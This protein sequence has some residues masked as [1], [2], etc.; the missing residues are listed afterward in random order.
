MQ[1]VIDFLKEN[2]SGVLA[3]VEEGT[4]RA[5]PFQFM[6]AENGKF[7]FCTN[8]T[9]EVYKQLQKTP[10]IEFSSMSPKFAWVRL[11]GEVV[12]SSE[13]A[14]KEKIFAISPLVKSLYKDPENPI[15]EVFYLEH[16]TAILAD[17]SGEP[18]KNFTF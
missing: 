14:C 7:F 10:Y 2:V 15:F 3:T 5:R 12:F 8:N 1:E 11:R 6:Y 18:P 9:K 4:P 13:L 16:G 17:F